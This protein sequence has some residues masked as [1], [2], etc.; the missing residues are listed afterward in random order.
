LSGP[1]ASTTIAAV[2][3]ESIPPEEP[4]IAPGNLFFL[5]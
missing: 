2:S 3:A 4:M 1:K 5:I